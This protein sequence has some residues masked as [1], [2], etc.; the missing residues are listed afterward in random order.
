MEKAK[1]ESGEPDIVL[2]E[3]KR[4]SRPSVPIWHKAALTLEEAAAFSN[5][6]VDKLREITNE[7]DSQLVVWVGRKRLILREQLVRFLEHAYSI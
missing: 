1:A 3:I 5:I 6:G 2:Q 4:K 7:E